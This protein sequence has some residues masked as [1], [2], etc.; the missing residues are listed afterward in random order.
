VALEL[1]KS[2]QG[3]YVRVGTYIGTVL[4]N[5]V[6]CWYLW[7]KLNNY[8]PSAKEDE[9]V[10]FVQAIKTYLE[11]G[12]PFLLFAGMVIVEW[13]YLNKPVAVDFLIATES[14]MK[15]V[16]WSSRAELFGSTLVVIVTVF[17]LAVMIFTVDF[18]I[19][20]GL[21]SGWTVPFTN[22]HIPGLGLWQ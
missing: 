3:R 9:P 4:V 2:G 19:A 15:K 16:S 6:L 21:S 12:I 14:E 1:Y 17:V 20:G 7:S 13:I 18:L 22:I 8:L 11:Y 5:L 10:T